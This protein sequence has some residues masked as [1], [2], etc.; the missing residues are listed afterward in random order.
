MI[1][2]IKFLEGQGYISERHDLKR[3][4]THSYWERRNVQDDIKANLK[5]IKLPFYH[6][7][8]QE[9]Y[10]FEYDADTIIQTFFTEF[11]KKITDKWFVNV[12][13]DTLDGYIL[14]CAVSAVDD[15]YV[16]RINNDNTLTMMNREVIT[17]DEL[18]KR[19]RKSLRKFH[20]KYIH[21]VTAALINREIIFD[22]NKVNVIFGPNGSGKTSILKEI[23][24]HAHCGD[25]IMVKDGWSRIENPYQIILPWWHEDRNS[26]K[27]IQ[28]WKEA[29]INESIIKWDG[30]PVYY[31]NFASVEKA[32]AHVFGNISK[33]SSLFGT[34]SELAGDIYMMLDSQKSKGESQKGMFNLL[35]NQFKNR[36]DWNSTIK[37]I[38]SI[39]NKG[40]FDKLL[41]VLEEY[42]ESK[43]KNT[44]LLDEP[45]SS[46]DMLTVA[47]FYKNVLPTL[48][49][50]TQIILVTHNPLIFLSNIC[51]PE[52]YNFISLDENYTLKCKSTILDN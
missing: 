6:D 9:Y 31:H 7:K 40:E 18:I 47:T 45:E 17:M 20:N 29:S 35:V 15:E 2:S 36:H 28:E 11:Q 33:K 49:K 27:W 43:S 4:Q 44:L 5:T 52:V 30:S 32:S 39:N 37:T 46:M 12:S 14:L 51:N 3:V 21:P 24:T 22:E 8:F 13:F 26:D 34:G 48:S 23:A 42:N 19:I 50:F 1:T 41:A 38:K 25:G 16:F 10:G